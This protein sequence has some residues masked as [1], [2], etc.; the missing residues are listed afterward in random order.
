MH[1]DVL[2]VSWSV[3]AMWEYQM[4]DGSA[5][6]VGRPDFDALLGT[7]MAEFEEMAAQYGTT[8]LWTT[9][10][11]KEPAA[12]GERWTAPK[13][14]DQ[15]AAVVLQ[16]PCTSDLRMLVRAEPGYRWYQDGYHFTPTGA[17]RA[18][19]SMTSS[20]LRCALLDPSGPDVL[21]GKS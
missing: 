4:A 2:V 10:A 3:T 11:P 7:R 12:G 19:A 15:M 18:V 6:Y 20:A 8:V 5:S 21:P 16:R 1:L 9:Y 17:A 14:A 13:T